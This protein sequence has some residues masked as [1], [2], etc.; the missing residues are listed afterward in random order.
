MLVKIKDFRDV[1][2]EIKNALYL[3]VKKRH[4]DVF[5]I[6]GISNENSFI[7]VIKKTVKNPSEV[8][9]DKLGTLYYLHKL[10]DLYINIV[11]FKNSAKTIYLVGMKSYRKMRLKK[12]LSKIF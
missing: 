4:P 7:Q 10:N 6:L 3:H 9:S 2:I 12:W 8:Y 5:R 1:E 11:T